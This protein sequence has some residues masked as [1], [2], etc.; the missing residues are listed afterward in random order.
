MGWVMQMMVAAGEEAR[1]CF[2][3]NLLRKAVRDYTRTS[4]APGGQSKYDSIS[5][6]A[7]DFN[8]VQSS[9]PAS[10]RQP[11]AAAADHCDVSAIAH[12]SLIQNEAAE[13]LHSWDRSIT[14]TSNCNMA[15]HAD[16]SAC[17]EE[18]AAVDLSRS[19]S[20]SPCRSTM[21]NLV[22]SSPSRSSKNN[23]QQGG[24]CFRAAII[25]T[26]T[27]HHHPSCDEV[28][29]CRQQNLIDHHHADA[30][31]SCPTTPAGTFHLP[32][33]S[34]SS[35]KENLMNPLEMGSQSS[36]CTDNPDSAV[37]KEMHEISRQFSP[38]ASGRTS[39]RSSN[40][41][42]QQQ[43]VRPA[44]HFLPDSTTLPCW[45]TLMNTGTSSCTTTT[46]ATAA[47]LDELAVP[48]CTSSKHVP[49]RFSTESN[50]LQIKRQLQPFNFPEADTTHFSHSMDFKRP[51]LMDHPGQDH[52][53]HH[54]L[55]SSRS[56]Y[57]NSNPADG[58]TL[59]ASHAPGSELPGAY[60]SLREPLSPTCYTPGAAAAAA[61]GAITAP[62]QLVSSF[63][64]G[65]FTSYGTGPSI[66]SFL[67]GPTSANPGATGMRIGHH[68]DLQSPRVVLWDFQE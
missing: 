22:N 49:S 47:V 58:F 61:T 1:R 54:V 51:H 62:A 28:A 9:D 36:S 34:A 19:N 67:S 4:S 29:S 31:I 21:Q 45:R 57:N 5:C 41:P 55:S 13:D 43:L 14:S 60:L 11:T 37:I 35:S 10:L 7:T 2:S 15:G 12:S 63:A 27:D 46:S 40:S 44:L 66:S 3:D 32:A 17:S 6:A 52:H 39:W 33:A 53:H 64:A 56:Q 16:N 30:A 65:P 38:A 23:M 24:S 26:A 18:D 50:L 8:L 68:Y 48:S 20:R 59:Q 25:S 42:H